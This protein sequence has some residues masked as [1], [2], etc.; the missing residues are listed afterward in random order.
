MRA[1]IVILAAALLGVAALTTAHAQEPTATPE[2]TGSISGRIVFEGFQPDFGASG[3]LAYVLI[4]LPGD[5]AQPIDAISN[6]SLS[7]ADAEGNFSFTGLVDG[8]YFISPAEGRLLE[9]S[10]PAPESVSIINWDVQSTLLAVRVT[11]ANG[12]AVT[13]IEIIIRLPEPVPSGPDVG[14]TGSDCPQPLSPP[15]GLSPPSGL[16]PPGGISPVCAPATGTG[17]GPTAAERTGAYIALAF[18]GL[19]ALL[20]AGGVALRARRLL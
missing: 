18:A 8:D 12:A 2:H 20:L 17:P 1:T 6:F 15:N 19:A 16:S 5:L 9:T 7:V 10:T 13:G 3:T 11:V 14:V 4:L